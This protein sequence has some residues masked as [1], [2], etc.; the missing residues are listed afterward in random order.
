M[1]TRYKSHARRYARGV[2]RPAAIA[3]VAV[4]AV[5][6]AASWF[7]IIK[8]HQDLVESEVGAHPSTPVKP[9]AEAPPPP[10]NV[11]AMSMNELLAEARKAVNEQRLLAPAGNN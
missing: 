1:D 7:L 4:V 9:G 10:V 2:I 6:A 3:I 11:A 5:L 8:P